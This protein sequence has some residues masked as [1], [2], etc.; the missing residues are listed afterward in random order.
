[1]TEICQGR[2]IDVIASGYNKEV[3]PYA[4]L[5]LISGLTDF[6]VSVEEPGPVL[7]RFQSDPSFGETREVVAEVKRY[8]REYWD[9][10]K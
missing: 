2:L 7:Q 4:W 3:L 8:H 10:L 9:C 1:M 6:D 5:A